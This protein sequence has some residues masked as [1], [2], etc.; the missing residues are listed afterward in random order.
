ME[1]AMVIT[2]YN[3]AKS[4]TCT[5]HFWSQSFRQ[6]SMLHVLS[7]E[8][9]V[10]HHK[11][12]RTDVVAIETSSILQVWS[13]TKRAERRS[14]FQVDCPI[15]IHS[16]N[17]D[18]LISM[19]YGNDLC[20][21]NDYLS[22]CLYVYNWDA[23]TMSVHTLQSSRKYLENPS[24]YPLEKCIIMQVI[25]SWTYHTVPTISLCGSFV[26]FH[27]NN[28]RKVL[29]CLNEVVEVYKVSPSQKFFY[30]VKIPNQFK[31][32]I[33][34]PLLLLLYSCQLAKDYGFDIARFIV[35]E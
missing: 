21:W 25:I 26:Q 15:K 8:M 29:V 22:T 35:Y 1:R 11:W 16:G 33:R 32:L 12:E 34:R 20:T 3:S 9:N 18:M 6:K 23:N 27:N 10:W 17:W 5:Q 4:Y 31:Q 2:S 30:W 14:S 7:L 13:G 28:S 19:A 24:M